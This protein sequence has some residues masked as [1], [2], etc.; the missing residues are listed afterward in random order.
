MKYLRKQQQKS[1]L[2]L[3][4]RNVKPINQ[5]AKWNT[6]YEKYRQHFTSIRAKVLILLVIVGLVFLTM[7][8]TTQKRIVREVKSAVAGHMLLPKN[9]EPTVAT[10]DDKTKLKDKFLT[11]HA[12]NGDQIL[13]YTQN[14]LVIIYRPSVDK[15]VAVGTVTADSAVAEAQNATLTVLDGAND[16]SKTQNITEQIKSIYPSMKVI[17]GGKANRQDFTSTLVIDNTKSKDYLVDA[18]A[19][20]IKGKRGIV[21]ISESLSTTDLMVIVGK[22]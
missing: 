11:T 4:L 5:K 3:D 19:L 13:I 10:V 12:N 22:E 20:N 18:I 14:Q 2:I 21:P 6:H 15:I 7:H 16:P 8:L 1:S 9:E 17:V